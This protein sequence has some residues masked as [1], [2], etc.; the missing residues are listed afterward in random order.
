ME[1]IATWSEGDRADL[2]RE[3]AAI[4]KL[5]PE[6][7]EKDFWVCWA[8][9]RLF[10]SPAM[11][12]KILFKGGTSLSKVFALIE[13]FSEDVNL[14]LDW[15]EVTGENPAAKRS[16]TGQDTFNKTLLAQAHDY[17]RD[18]FLPEVQQLVGDVCEAVIEDNPEVIN[19]QYAHAAHTHA[20][21]PG[22]TRLHPAPRLQP[23]RPRPSGP[24]SR[25][26]S[27]VDWRPKPRRWGGVN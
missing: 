25:T 8:L 12:G 18:T 19:L 14:V 11:A 15:R 5:A 24:G 7:V 22:C 17:L 6:I 13:R 9:G 2:V 16:V 4:R 20:C 21:C 23:P 3:A 26:Q 27:V 10:G 1:H